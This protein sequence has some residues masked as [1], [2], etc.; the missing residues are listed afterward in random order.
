MRK[1]LKLATILMLC[2]AMIPAALGEVAMLVN[3]DLSDANWIYD[4]NLLYIAQSS[5]YGM[6]SV[7]GEALTG[8]LYRSFSASKG[9][10]T[11]QLSSPEDPLNAG[12]LFD[13]TG[14]TLIP[15]QYGDVRVE[16]TEWAL[17]VVLAE[18]QADN[19]DYENLSGDS[20]YLIQSV[21]VYHLPEGKCVATLT[22]DQFVDAQAVNHCL[23]IQSRSDNTI[24]CYDA[25]F[26]QLGTGLSDLSDDTYAPS[27]FQT[28]REN[29]QEGV[30]DAEGN[31]I[32]EPSFNYVE[33]TV[34]GG[35]FRVSTGEYY[36]LADLNGNVVVPA[37]YD[38]IKSGINAP[39]DETGNYSSYV[40]H[41]YAIVVKDGKIGYVAVGDGKVTCEPTYAEKSF[42]D[43]S[44]MSSML[45]DLEG[46]VHIVA[47][48][49]VDTVLEGYDEVRSLSYSSGMFYRVANADGLVGMIDWHGNEV[50]PCEFSSLS[51]SGDGQYVL[52]DSADYKSCSIY[53][54]T[55]A[56]A[57]AAASEEA[58]PE[59][60]SAEETVAGEGA[61]ADS[62]AS[63]EETVAGEGA[64][65]D[66]AESA[67]EAPAD[68]EASGDAASVVT[69]LE[70]AVTL[71]QADAAAN[72]D[73]V[74]GLLDGATALLGPD[75]PAT[76]VI[77][78][79]VALL[80]Q[81]AAANG[82]SAVTVLES[83]MGMV[84]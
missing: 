50:L 39:V 51:L 20:F 13:T 31:V 83:A 73:A 38:S 2:I 55:Y 18:A 75:H 76:A 80:E 5:G 25:E 19:Y 16:S 42:Q 41:G 59:E 66:S 12:G 27:D 30:M 57:G 14:A 35:Y 33:T 43:I 52:V 3:K 15:F 24:S 56:E 21:D 6:Y 44:G 36:G 47:A 61:N 74:I 48:D 40:A 70:S 49:G 8:D 23:N 32:M 10:I 77:N 9:Y 29:G 84:S 69:V 64:D 4:S 7:E 58:A 37:E 53:K 22:R 54:L 46:N 72:K 63:A 67:E 1:V 34:R 28:F 26:N 82:A 17:G 81:D 62:A 68:A 79:A 11:A 65:V 60:A 45:T 71:L 78:G